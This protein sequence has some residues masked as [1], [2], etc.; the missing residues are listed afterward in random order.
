MFRILIFATVAM[1]PAVGNAAPLLPDFDAAM[2]APGQQITNPYF[3]LVPDHHA[4]YLAEG[5]D[6]EGPFSERSQHDFAGS[7]PQILG[8]GTTVLRDLAF[9]DGVIV[10]E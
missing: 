6:A 10:E 8:I 4:V 3:P 5:V 7:G 2:F 1:A 9:E